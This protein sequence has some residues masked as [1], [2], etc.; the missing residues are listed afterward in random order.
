MVHLVCS[1]LRSVTNAEHDGFQADTTA[2][3][4][5]GFLIPHWLACFVGCYWKK[6]VDFSFFRYSFSRRTILSIR[7]WTNPVGLPLLLLLL[8]P[9]ELLCLVCEAGFVQH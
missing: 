8:L 2:T 1:N 3:V 7:S 5:H 4:T 6:S 9:G